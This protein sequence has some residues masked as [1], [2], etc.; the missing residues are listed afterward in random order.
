MKLKERKE[1]NSQIKQ[2]A[3]L[4]AAKSIVQENGI[5]GLTIR[6]TAQM[7]GFSVCII[8]E[9]FTSKEA[10]LK[11]LFKEVS[12]ELVGVLEQVKQQQNS[13]EEYIVDLFSKDIEF[14]LEKPYRVELFAAVIGGLSREEFPAAMREIADCFGNAI[15]TLGYPCLMSQ[16]EIHDALD[17]LRAMLSGV[18]NMAVRKGSLVHKERYMTIMESGI[19]VLLDGWKARCNLL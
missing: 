14:M 19:R 3:I 11:A 4:S 5:E 16:N 1:R 8:Y 17:I 15:R 13:A 12:R 10:I 9:H 6:K 7:I 2:E 18:L